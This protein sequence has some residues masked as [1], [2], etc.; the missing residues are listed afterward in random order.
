M[1]L[2]LKCP[3]CNRTLS[4]PEELLGHQVRCPSCTTTFI[5]ASPAP[6]E[7]PT[8]TEAITADARPPDDVPRR[9]AD[10]EDY[11]RPPRRRDDEPFYGRPD[12]GVLVMVLGI[13]GLVMAVMG[14]CVMPYVLEPVAF[15]M[16]LTAWILGQLDRKA[17]A[18]ETMD[19]RGRESTKA[20][21]ICGII[22]TILAVVIPT[23]YCVFIMGYVGLLLSLGP[24]GH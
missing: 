21:W 11:L 24:K 1:P 10:D 14:T 9:A 12:R 8:A 19:P 20:G 18:A 7:V 15:G 2:Q 4:V 6:D 22:G 17:I 23:C 5:A 16:S 3:S 13:V